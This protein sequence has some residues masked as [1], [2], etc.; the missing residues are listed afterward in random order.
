MT[1]KYC[2]GKFLIQ[3][4]LICVFLLIGGS[5]FSQC[6]ELV[7]PYVSLGCERDVN[8]YNYIY[9]YGYNAKTV[10]I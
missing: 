10:K 4:F 9:D 8:I 2:G 3:V 1:K 7:E 6:H 5:A